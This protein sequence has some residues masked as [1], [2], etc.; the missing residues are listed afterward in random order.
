M[1]TGADG[2]ELRHHV[3]HA[4]ARWVEM[5]VHVHA[6][7]VSVSKSHFRVC[8]L[9]LCSC[10]CVAGIAGF[11]VFQLQGGS[12]TASTVFTTFAGHGDCSHCALYLGYVP[13]MT[14]VHVI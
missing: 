14:H 3:R 13:A 10:A 1:F 2:H 6:L 5:R 12:I 9:P 7:C 8:R 4:R 11:L